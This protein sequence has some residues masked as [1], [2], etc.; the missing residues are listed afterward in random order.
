[1]TMVTIE[2]TAFTTVKSPQI[3]RPQTPVLI[4]DETYARHLARLRQAMAHAGLDAVV[5]Y[6][7]KEH[8]DNFYYFTG[9]EPRFEEAALVVRRDSV[10]IVLGNE[11]YKMHQYSRVTAKPVLCP[12]FSLPNQ[13]MEGEAPMLDVWAQ[14]GIV[15]GDRVGVVGW[16]LFTAALA[17]NDSVFDVPYYW[18]TSLQQAVGAQGRL[19]N[20]ARLL[21]G[22]DTGVRTTLE[23]DEIAYYEQNAAWASACVED[24]LSELAPGQTERELA[25][26]L[27]AFGQVVPCHPMCATGDRFGGAEV[28]PREKAVRLGDKFTT[29][30]S[31][32]GGLTCRA[33]YVA[34]SQED[35]PVEVRDYVDALARPYF[36]AIATWY[37]TIGLGVTGGD[38]YDAVQTV[39]PKETYGWFLNPGHLCASEEWMSSPIEKGSSAVLK[40][41]MIFQMDIIPSLPPY[42]SIN[43]EEGVALAD[44]ALRAE[45]AERYPALW[46][47]VAQRRAYMQDELGLVLKPEVLPLSNL[48]ACIR[49]F[50]LDR[51]KGLKALR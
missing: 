23:A 1:M 2:Q 33:A 34:R 24:L 43:A 46:E 14:S 3:A 18:V 4:S 17:D 5:L 25:G 26:H 40:S 49:P 31:L 10:A 51:T 41:G 12:Y 27:S 50:L 36:A 9:F 8:G 15:P 7:D 20:A 11:M 13:P 32:R 29:S 42:A 45:L 6:A 39:F 48:A 28:S 35:L 38:L 30:M 21:I 22:P 19:T 37:E 16:K 44:E 47:R